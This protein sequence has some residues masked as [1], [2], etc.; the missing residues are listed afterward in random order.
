LAKLDADCRRFGFGAGLMIANLM[1]AERAEMT[2][3]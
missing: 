2:L 3:K 1:S